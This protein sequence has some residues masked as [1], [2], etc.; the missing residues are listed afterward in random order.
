MLYFYD[1]AEILQHFF[2]NVV[3][4]LFFINIYNMSL[5]SGLVA[6]Y[7]T[8]KFVLRQISR[9]RLNRLYFQDRLKV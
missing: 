4:F 3:E 1:F 9:R 2:K 5:V 7:A 8:F 6:G